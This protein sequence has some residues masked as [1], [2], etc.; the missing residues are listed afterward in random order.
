VVGEM[1]K[2]KMKPGNGTIDEEGGSKTAFSE[3]WPFDQELHDG[4]PC[5]AA[6]KTAVTKRDARL[7]QASSELGAAR[8][9]DVLIAGRW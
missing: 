7:Q 3:P 9:I 4:G 2:V 8:N 6:H 5:G 1:V